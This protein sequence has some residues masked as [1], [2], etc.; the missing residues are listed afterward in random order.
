MK[1]MVFAI[2]LSCLLLPGLILAQSVTTG[3]FNG[4]VVDADG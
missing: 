2:I 3:A 4:I 1:K